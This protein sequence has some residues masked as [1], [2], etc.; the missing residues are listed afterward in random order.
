MPD[1]ELADVL[2]A[3]LASAIWQTNGVTRVPPGVV[4]SI[5]AALCDPA[6]LLAV[7]ELQGFTVLTGWERLPAMDYHPKEGPPRLMVGIKPRRPER[8]RE[9]VVLRP[10]CPTCGGVGYLPECCQTPL[11]TGECCAEPVPTPCPDCGDYGPQPPT[12][13]V[14]F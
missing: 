5:V 12:N 6:L 10:Q 3:S 14:P 13:D 9:Y 7:A 1:D 11:S 8:W 2:H 4:E